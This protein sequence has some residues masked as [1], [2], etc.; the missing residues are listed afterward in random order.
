MIIAIL[1]STSLE[2]TYLL[3]D[4]T[5]FD[6]EDIQDIALSM[7]PMVQQ[8]TLTKITELI[9][10]YKRVAVAPARS[11]ARGG[12]IVKTHLSSTERYD[13]AENIF[14]DIDWSNWGMDGVAADSDEDW[15]IKLLNFEHGAM[16]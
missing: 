14:D 9:A 6:D 3:C 13:I 10:K 4:Q 8:A 7:L 16:D 11:G 12:R 15:I 1:Y 5:M 2:I